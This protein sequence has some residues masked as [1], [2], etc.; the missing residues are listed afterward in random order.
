MYY[1]TFADPDGNQWE[2]MFSDTN[3]LSQQG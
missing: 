2:V 3:L 1:D